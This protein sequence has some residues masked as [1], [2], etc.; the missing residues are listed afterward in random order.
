MNKTKLNISQITSLAIMAALS[1]L[2][3]V[4]IRIPFP[5]APYLVYD[6]ADIPIYI[7][8]FALGPGAGILIT[9]VVSTIQAFLLGGD[10]VY[11]FIMHFIST[12]AFAVITG[13]LYSVNKT[14]RRAFLSVV[15]AGILVL[16]LMAILNY[17]ITPIYTGMPR[18]AVLAII[19]TIILP[20]NLIKI[21]INSILTI[22]IYK[23]VSNRLFHR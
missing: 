6:P 10:G 7:T 19:P 23:R 3:L 18:Q 1:I 14:K 9:F 13:K 15:I 11:G 21:G 4:L 16:L 5:A 12:G 2:L 20:F 17:Y 22:L 8:S